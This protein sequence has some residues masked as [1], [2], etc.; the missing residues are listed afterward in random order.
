MAAAKVS[1]EAKKH[2]IIDSVKARAKSLWAHVEEVKNTT[3]T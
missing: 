3:Q 1:T 2:G